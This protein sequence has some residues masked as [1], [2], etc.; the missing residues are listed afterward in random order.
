MWHKDPYFFRV[1]SELLLAVCMQCEDGRLCVGA[2]QAMQDDHVTESNKSRQEE[3]ENLGIRS[4]I[5]KQMKSWWKI[6]KDSQIQY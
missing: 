2:K 5:L 4:H 1:P 6:R 3:A